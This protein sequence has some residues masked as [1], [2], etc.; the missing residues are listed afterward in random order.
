MHDNNNLKYATST[1]DE[2]PLMIVANIQNK[3][4]H[5]AINPIYSLFFLN[6]PN[7]TLGPI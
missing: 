1:G 3:I 6:V 2:N 5:N 7:T 4:K